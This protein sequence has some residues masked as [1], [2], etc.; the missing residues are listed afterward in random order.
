MNVLSLGASLG[1]VVSVFQNG[2]FAEW[3][4]ITSTG[5]VMATVPI[6][7]FCIVFG[8]SMDYEV[9]LLSR[10]AEEYEATGDNER[11]TAE[12]L[13]KTGSLIT[14]A[15]FILIVVVGAF[16]LTDNEIMKAL[17]LGLSLAVL[18]DATL[19]RLFMVP[20][21]MKLLGRANWWAPRWA[22]RRRP[23]NAGSDASLQ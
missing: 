12:G 16:I 23:D 14:S 2:H 10:I 3:L 6:I 7:I 19:I 18:I 9:F 8:I 1:I 20:A 22:R 17:G 5:Y 15:A 4:H 13:M 11:S 21:L